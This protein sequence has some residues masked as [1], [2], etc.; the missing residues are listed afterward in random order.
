[1]FDVVLPVKCQGEGQFLQICFVL[2]ACIF[3]HALDAAVLT[4]SSN[5]PLYL[6]AAL[7]IFSSDWQHCLGATLL[8]FASRVPYAHDATPLSFSQDLSSS[9]L[10]QVACNTL[11]MLC[12]S[13]SPVTSHTLSL[14]RAELSN[15]L[16][17][18]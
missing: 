4:F 12:L 3:Q 1:M 17:A 14:L 15:L 11:L 18:S 7:L 16:G 2:F 13:L 5:L 8:T 9:E 10:S 6:D